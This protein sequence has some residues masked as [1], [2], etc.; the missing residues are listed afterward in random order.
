M[1]QCYDENEGEGID[2]GLC[3]VGRTRRNAA[4][5]VVVV[6]EWTGE[7]QVEVGNAGEAG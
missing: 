7:S 1:R 5:L 4:A 2:R 6:V 3:F